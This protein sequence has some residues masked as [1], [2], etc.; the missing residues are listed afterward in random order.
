MPWSSTT[1]SSLCHICWFEITSPWLNGYFF[2][3]VRMF[4]VFFVSFSLFLHSFL[5]VFL[6]ICFV[7][8]SFFLPLVLFFLSANSFNGFEVCR[9][10]D[11]DM[12]CDALTGVRS[13]E[14]PQT[15]Q[16]KRIYTTYRNMYVFIY[17][18]PNGVRTRDSSSF[19]S[20]LL[21]VSH[22]DEGP[23]FISTS[24]W[25]VFVLPRVSK[26]LLDFMAFS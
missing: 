10:S 22:F 5:Y 2:Y 11:W 15:T 19:L 24:S 7:F 13:T 4:F 20:K 25:N 26:T 18:V 8:V 21:F 23:N 14:T 12:G 17:Y 1:H 9:L 6:L 16:K 3:L